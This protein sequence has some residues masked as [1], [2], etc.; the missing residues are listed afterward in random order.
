MHALILR[1]ADNLSIVVF[2]TPRN[3]GVFRRTTGAQNVHAD[4]AG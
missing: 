1:D 2:R 4:S 3:S